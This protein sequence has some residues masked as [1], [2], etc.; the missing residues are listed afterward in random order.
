MRTN[1]QKD[2]SGEIKHPNTYFLV[3]YTKESRFVEAHFQDSDCN[4]QGETVAF[5]DS[6]KFCAK[7]II[8]NT[9]TGDSGSPLMQMTFEDVN[10][11][12]VERWHVVGVLSEGPTDCEKE[13]SQSSV[14][15]KVS[16]FH[17]WINE[18]IDEDLEAT[19]KSGK[20]CSENDKHQCG[21]CD[22]GYQLNKVGQCE[23]LDLA[24][25]FDRFGKQVEVYRCPE[26]CLERTTGCNF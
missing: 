14:F 20:Y 22:F 26:V 5:K 1:R 18:I 24:S 12:L 2:E 10:G 8:S 19:S 4:I 15:T 7:S 16:K 23:Q 6:P 3:G 13:E 11:K 25:T 21:S 17:D 9:C